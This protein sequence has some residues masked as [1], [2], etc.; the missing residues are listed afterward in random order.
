MQSDGKIIL[1]NLIRLNADGTQDNSFNAGTGISGGSG[2]GSVRINKILVQPD[3]KILIGG[4]YGSYNGTT[5]VLITRLNSDGTID[6]TFNANANF[7]PAMDGF[8]GQVYSIKLLPNGKIMIGG[9]Y[10]NNNTSTLGVDRLNID[11]SLDT[12][13]KITHSFSGVRNYAL[14]VQSD[15]KI[16]AA[17]V[18]FGLPSE[19]FVVERYNIDG[20]LDTIFPKRFVN[21][22]VKDLIVQA[23]GKITFVGYF[24]YNPTGIMRLIGDTPMGVTEMSN[25]LFEMYPNPASNFLNLNIGNENA[26]V[27]IINTEGRTVYEGTLTNGNNIIDINNL[28]PGFY[29]CMVNINGKL[30][31][32]KLI[33][34]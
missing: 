17:N 27:Q 6:N 31:N 13:F 10:A 28:L 12:T 18:N 32:K 29:V 30:S 20:S 4:H 33:I 19:A 24:N 1:G 34:K 22:D 5:S 2:F 15:G 9:N 11:G 7:A 14:D 8:Y 25:S 26:I 23:D 21:N 16:L 3:G